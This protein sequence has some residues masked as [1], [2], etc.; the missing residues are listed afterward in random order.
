MVRFIANVSANN[1]HIVDSYAIRKKDF[2]EVLDRLQKQ[3]PSCL[4]FEERNRFS[5]CCEWATHNLLYII[6]SERLRAHVKDVD[7][8]TPLKWYVS[9]AYYVV[10]VFALLFI[11]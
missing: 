4:V 3:H 9:L 5:M 8:N 6:P 10:G 7:I 1:I 2:N 11:R